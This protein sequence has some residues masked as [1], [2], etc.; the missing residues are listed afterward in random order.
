MW[1][2]TGMIVFQE[3][4]NYTTR[5]L[6]FIFC[7]MVVC[8]I[9]IYFLYSK[10]KYMKEIK[11]QKSN[12]RSNIIDITTDLPKTSPKDDDY[13]LATRSQIFRRSQ[14]VNVSST[15]DNKTI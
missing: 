4:G 11:T 7:A 8:C 6:T 14:D 3:T 1:I 12:I 15:T 5:E 9:G 2:L 13:M 10:T